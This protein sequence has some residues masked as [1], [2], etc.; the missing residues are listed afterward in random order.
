MNI[1]Q[2]IK[3]TINEALQIITITYLLSSIQVSL[4]CTVFPQSPWQL[5]RRLTH[6]EAGSAWMEG[7][8]L[9]GE[10]WRTDV[11]AGTVTGVP[12]VVLKVSLLSND[13]YTA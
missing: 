8:V 4:N 7:P 1:D 2:N 12:T 13:I 10:G 11:S 9:T 6:V 5:S 3:S